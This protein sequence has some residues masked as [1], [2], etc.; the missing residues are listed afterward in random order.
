MWLALVLPTLCTFSCDTPYQKVALEDDTTLNEAS[1]LIFKFKQKEHG[2]ITCVLNMNHHSHYKYMYTA[3]TIIQELLLFT[4]VSLT[5]KEPSDTWNLDNVGLCQAMIASR[6]V[7]P[8]LF[9]SH[10][11]N[12]T[13]L[14]YLTSIYH[15]G[16]YMS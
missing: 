8:I 7:H 3:G 9:I 4:W 12:S 15:K 2:L 13:V 1:C 5:E 16:R 14:P 11:H 6:F 10:A